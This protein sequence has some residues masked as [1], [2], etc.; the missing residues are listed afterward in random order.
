[1]VQFDF[2]YESQWLVH[3]YSLVEV[4]VEECILHVKLM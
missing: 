1:M 3:I 4:T 2:I